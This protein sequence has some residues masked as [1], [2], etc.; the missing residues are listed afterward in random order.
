MPAAALALFGTYRNISFLSLQ[1]L[2][3]R[4]M[5][6]EQNTVEL[7][8][9]FRR[10]SLQ[11]RSSYAFSHKEGY[12]D[13]ISRG[14]SLRDKGPRVRSQLNGFYSPPLPGKE[15]P[16]PSQGD[17]SNPTSTELAAQLC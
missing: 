17:T 13:L 15:A 6:V 11:R 7:T 8:S 4:D 14:A 9:H 3:A 5:R 10:N 2:Q 12:A 16:V 1:M